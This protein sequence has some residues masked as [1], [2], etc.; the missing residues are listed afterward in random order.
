MP[1][2]KSSSFNSRVFAPT[3]PARKTDAARKVGL[4]A[5]HQAHES[6]LTFARRICQRLRIVGEHRVCR[7]NR[8]CRQNIAAVSQPPDCGQVSGN[9]GAEQFPDIRALSGGPR[10]RFVLL[11]LFGLNHAKAFICYR[12][13]SDNTSVTTM[14]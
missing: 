10:Q 8:R 13:V 7:E 3:D 5:K 14:R 1:C 11:Q 6:F 4:I 2:W 12:C 9:A